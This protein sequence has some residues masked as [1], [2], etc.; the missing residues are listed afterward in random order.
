M[1]SGEERERLTIVRLRAALR[2]SIA[3]MA[4]R[5]WVAVSMSA[6]AAASSVVALPLLLTVTLL[7]VRLSAGCS[8]S[9]NE[10]GGEGGSGVQM[11]HVTGQL[12]RQRCVVSQSSE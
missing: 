4:C 5:S 1:V 2:G 9:V 10:G 7:R 8:P 11:P 6:D 12:H 3:A